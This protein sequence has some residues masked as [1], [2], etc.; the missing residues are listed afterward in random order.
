[1]G[2][3]AVFATKINVCFSTFP[4][5]HRIPLKSTFTSYASDPAAAASMAATLSQQAAAEAGP[6][7]VIY[8]IRVV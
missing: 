2:I 6:G 1:M 7:R 5:K 4:L 3:L 8:P